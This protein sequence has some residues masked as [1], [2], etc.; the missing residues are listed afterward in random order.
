MSFD[1]FT[2]SLENRF[3]SARETSEILN[4]FFTSKQSRTYSEYI[5]L[6]LDAT[7]IFGR[8]CIHSGPLIKQVIV[9]SPGDIKSLLLPAV[10]TSS[11]WPGFVKKAEEAARV[12]FPERIINELVIEKGG[13]VIEEVKGMEQP[14]I[15]MGRR[16]TIPMNVR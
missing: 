6:L 5:E 10:E 4:G 9:R 14:S 11:S 12:A 1:Q 15:S 3:R 8:E 13:S 2:S 7:E 16:V